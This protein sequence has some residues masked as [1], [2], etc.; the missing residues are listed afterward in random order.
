VLGTGIPRNA[1]GQLDVD[2]TDGTLVAGTYGR[3]AWT[4]PTGV[5]APALVLKPGDTGQPVGPGSTL[6]Y[7][8]TVR[9]IGNAAATG[10]TVTAPIPSDTT[11]KA[12]S[13][14]GTYA[15]DRA[16]WAGLTIPAGGS[17]TL[18]LAVT[19][20][21]GL[22]PKTT[23]LTLD[24]VTVTS[25][26]GPGTTGSPYVVPIS[27]AHALTIAPASQTDG[28]RTGSTVD[29]PVTVRNL[30][31]LADSVTLTTAGT[32]TATVLDATCT[33]AKAGTGSIAPGA[34]VPAC[35]RVTIP[36]GTPDSTTS[37]TTVTATSDTSPTT[38]AAA[39]IDTIAVAIDTLFVDEDGNA[40]DTSK[41]YTD[42]LTSTGT[43]FATW[44]LG[45]KPDLPAGFLAAH[46]TVVWGT[47]NTYP[48]PITK[49]EPALTRLLNGGGR[50]FLSGQDLLDQ[51]A[52]QTDFVK[53]YLHVSWD[54]SETQNDKPTATVTGQAGD[55]VA[56]SQGTVPIDHSVLG[57]TYEDQITPL[58][59]ASPAFK[60]DSAQTDGLSVAAANYKVVFLAFPFEAYGTAA[61]KAS[62][63]TSS[64]TWFAAP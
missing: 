21:P 52:G 54:G 48:A 33:A 25:A 63:M 26:Q 53:D 11:Y 50:L 44:D 40:P 38:T 17:K 59:P 39:G 43:T 23:S 32:W 31:Y 14:G 58:A 57:A 62:L 2:A 8:L 28:G 41:Y 45:A 56:A 9:N 16:T 5:K 15:R 1:I 47:G 20:A 24:G 22:K 35:I 4:L 3:G 29:Y 37:H 61:Q 18:T 27:P 49:Y 55:P 36:A 13:D 7:T 34:S 51:T 64:L 10:V 30:G 46:K 60:D 12:S 6:T 42:A 19:V